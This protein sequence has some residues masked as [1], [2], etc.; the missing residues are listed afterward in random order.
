MGAGAVFPRMTRRNGGSSPIS[1]E[2][3][4]N[5][6]RFAGRRTGSLGFRRT[7]IA[8]GRFR[9]GNEQEEPEEREGYFREVRTQ[10]HLADYTLPDAGQ[11]TINDSN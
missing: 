10:E 7:G 4:G 3:G 1:V 8:L 9:N 5:R 11:A 6:F 2:V